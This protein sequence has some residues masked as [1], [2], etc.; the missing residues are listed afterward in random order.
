MN[1][2]EI[3]EII[4]ISEQWLAEHAERFDPFGWDDPKEK[5]D[6]RKAFAELG[7]YVYVSEKL[8][9]EVHP[10][11]RDTFESSVTAE[12]YTELV[13]RYPQQARLY[14]APLA[15]AVALDLVDDSVA[16]SARQ[17]LDHPALVP[18]QRI[19]MRELDLA[20][21]RTLVG[22]DPHLDVDDIIERSSLS[23]PPH[24]IQSGLNEAYILT[25]DVFYCYKFGHTNQFLDD[26]SEY[27]L[28]H[29]FDGLSLR[30]MGEGHTDIALELVMTG[31]LMN[32]ISNTTVAAVVDWIA[33]AAGEHEFVPGPPNSNSMSITSAEQTDDRGQDVSDDG[34]EWDQNYHTNLIAAMTGKVLLTHGREK[35]DL[36]EEVPTE[37]ASLASI[38]D[39]LS[40]YKLREGANRLRNAQLPRESH[41]SVIE[42]CLDFLR[43]QRG[44]DGT[45]GHWP[46]ER[47]QFVRQGGKEEQFQKK[48]VEK[49]SRECENTLKEFTDNEK[50]R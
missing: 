37:V 48:L 39:L 10:R 43:S 1:L 9:G 19:P 21:L 49:V 35:F 30:Y 23:S 40:K 45:F 32:Q 8:T 34:D 36:D 41:H 24:V 47:H 4:D 25:H 28:T 33:S 44:A 16:S 12:S 26:P 15:C 6:Q 13:K 14:A 22:L 11:L 20:Q 38:V 17:V 50:D 7:M 27:N 3:H 2:N 31:V 42:Q 5:Y 18:K 29:T 46:D